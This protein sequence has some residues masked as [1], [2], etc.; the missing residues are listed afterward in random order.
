MAIVPDFVRLLVTA[1]LEPLLNWFSD[2]IYAELLKRADD[3]F[4]IQLRATLDFT[5]LDSA[6]AA[7]HHA[8]GPGAGPT[9][10]VPHLVRALLIGALFGWSLRQLEF[11]IRFHLLIKWFVGYPLFA[12]GPDHSTL[13]RFEQWVMEHRHRTLFDEVLRQIDRDFPDERTQTQ[14]GDTFALR[15]NAAKESLVH[16]LRHTARLAYGRL[17]L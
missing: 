16:L 13:E 7:F 4:L 5:P 1:Y 3:H 11:Q 10:P 9:H 15:A 17:K 2:Q 14:I 8:E 6:C 12:A